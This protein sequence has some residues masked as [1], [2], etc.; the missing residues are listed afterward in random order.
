MSGPLCI[1]CNGVRLVDI[2]W[3]LKEAI[4]EF[5]S[6]GTKPTSFFIEAINSLHGMN[7]WAPMRMVNIQKL[8][9]Y[10]GTS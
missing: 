3:A 8:N 7:Q 9:T 6:L 2:V 5:E 10:L 1:L 4:N